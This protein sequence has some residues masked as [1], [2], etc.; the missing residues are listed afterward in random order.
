MIEDLLH[1]TD[2]HVEWLMDHEW[3]Q[4]LYAQTEDQVAKLRTSIGVKVDGNNVAARVPYPVPKDEKEGAPE[5]KKA[6]F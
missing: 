6:A 1:K 5:E 2:H 3:A 4:K